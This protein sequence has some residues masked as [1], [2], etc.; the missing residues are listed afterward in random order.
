MAV[1]LRAGV[2]ASLRPVRSRELE[3]ASILRSTLPPASRWVARTGALPKRPHNAV[4]RCSSL[5]STSVRPLRA[6]RNARGH[7]RFHLF[8]FRA[9]LIRPERPLPAYDMP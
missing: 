9:G 2:P 4:Q 7:I 3:S 1:G 8:A 5:A 6:R